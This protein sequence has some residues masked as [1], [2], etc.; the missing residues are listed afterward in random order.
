MA[1]RC[2]VEQ[3]SICSVVQIIILFESHWA[4]RENLSAI[5][6]GNKLPS[7]AMDNGGLSSTKWLFIIKQNRELA[8]GNEPEQK[9]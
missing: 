2:L 4:Q 6:G 1:L 5:P 7:C 8:A 3:T 9:D